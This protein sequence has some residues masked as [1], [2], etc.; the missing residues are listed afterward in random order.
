MVG[1]DGCSSSHMMQ[2]TATCD[3]DQV[4][5]ESQADLLA[6]GSLKIS[7]Q[8]MC[9]STLSWPYVGTRHTSSAEIIQ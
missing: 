4:L 2:K 7:R 8:L 9:E 3:V 5:M 1:R 6:S